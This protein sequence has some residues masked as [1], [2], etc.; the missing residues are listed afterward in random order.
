MER[1]SKSCLLL[2]LGLF[3]IF[4]AIP[5]ASQGQVNN[6]SCTGTSPCSVWSGSCVNIGSCACCWTGAKTF[7]YCLSDPGFNCVNKTPTTCP[8]L[9][10]GTQTDCTPG[11]MC[12]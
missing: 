1:A 9:C 12:P 8:G 2:G 4:L 3:L 7:E 6:Y 5:S 11:L 10:Q